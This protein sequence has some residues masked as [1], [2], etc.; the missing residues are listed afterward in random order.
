LVLYCLT[1][2]VGSVVDK[3][4]VMENEVDGDLGYNWLKTNYAGSGPFSLRAWRPNESLTSSA[5]R[6]T[7]RARRPCPGDHRH[8]AEA[9][10][11]Q[12][13]LEQGDIDVARNLGPDQ[14]EALEGNADI[15]Q[16]RAQGRHLLSRAQPE[17]R[18]SGQARGAPGAEV[19]R[20]YQGMAETI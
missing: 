16:E 6:T 5:T 1:A 7:G 17:E 9:A 20:D 11:Q 12:L 2:T 4:L 15:Y 10:T 18:E 19:P 3:E 14:V 13:L 8:I